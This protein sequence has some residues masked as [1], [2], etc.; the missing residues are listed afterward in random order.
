LRRHFNG[1]TSEEAK[2]PMYRLVTA[3]L[4]VSVVLIAAGCGANRDEGSKK[5]TVA[6]LLSNGGDPYFQNKSYGYIQAEKRLG[7]VDVQLFDAGGYENSE[8]QISQMEDAIQRKVD[9]IV[10]TPVDSKALCGPIKEAKDAGIPVV[11]DDIMPECD[12]KVPV[13]ISENSVDVGANECKY[14]AQAIGHKGNFVMMKGPPGA[15]IAIDRAK[16]CKDALKRYPGIKVLGEQWGPS[17]IETGNN[18]M[19]DFISAHGRKIN[20]AYTFGAVTALGAV[21]AMQSAG[22]KPGSIELATID[23][24]P[25]VLKYMKRG[26]L[27]GTIPAQPVRLAELTTKAA[28]DLADDKK[29]AGKRGDPCC[30]VRSYTGDETVIDNKKLP[31]YDD[32]KAVAPAGWKPP[33][34]G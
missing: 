14:M 16:G 20:A 25:E 12:Q 26:W 1:K 18:L 9:A 19:D 11:A 33:L 27:A 29:V 24:H 23:L 7:N 13:G 10:L 31:S 4:I 3:A 34:Q 21:N 8:K 32:S 15:K 5:K 2:D 6:V 22:Y 30:D 17:N 28:V